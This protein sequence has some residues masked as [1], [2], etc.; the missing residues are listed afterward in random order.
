MPKSLFFYKKNC[1]NKIPKGK[2]LNEVD[3]TLINSVKK[4]IPNL[5]NLI[6]KQNLNDYIKMV[7]RFSFDANK[8][9]NDSEPWSLKKS[10]PERMNSILFTISEQIKNISILLNPIIP[11][12]TNK[13][14]QTMNFKIKDV[15]IENIYKDGTLDHINELKELE[16][17]FKKVENDN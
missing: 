13:V 5:I 7:V 3:M 15:L 6:N 12:S 4:N 11:L 8:Y 17:L 10:N 14:L 9:F 2:N 16:I 1:E